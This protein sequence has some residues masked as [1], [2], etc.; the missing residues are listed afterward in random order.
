[1]DEDDMSEASVVVYEADTDDAKAASGN[2]ALVDDDD[3]DSDEEAAFRRKL[4]HIKQRAQASVSRDGRPPLRSSES[5]H[6]RAPE[7]K[8][9]L[10]APTKYSILEVPI[11][12]SVVRPDMSK[13]NPKQGISQLVWSHDT[14]FLA[15]RNDNIPNT[16][17]IWETSLLSL[18][19][20]VT[21]INP[22]RM[23]KWSPTTCKL[24]IC[25]NSSKVYF[26][27]PDG[28]SVVDVPA[29]DFSVR[30]FQWN[31]D[32]TSLSLSSANKFCCAYAGVDFDETNPVHG[33]GYD[34]DGD[35]DQ[36]Y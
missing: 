31:P 4:A 19:C 5:F 27:S 6:R 9:S 32:G 30:S 1:V 24:A 10:S 20:V 26:W 35:D 12:L 23:F 7:K 25:T 8:Q 13:P 22:V 16:V 21:H 28:A 36:V 14:K 17:W 3:D 33:D 11:E 18:V 2:T 34:N 15:T 29:Q